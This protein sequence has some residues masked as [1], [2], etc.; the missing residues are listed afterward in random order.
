[1]RRPFP[2]GEQAVAPV[3]DTTGTPQQLER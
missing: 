2:G 1:M 3:R